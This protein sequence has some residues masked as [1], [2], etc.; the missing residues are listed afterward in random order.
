MRTF[1]KCT[2]VIVAAGVALATTPTID[3]LNIATD[4]A[5]AAIAT[6]DTNTQFGDNENEL[7][8]MFVTSDAGNMYIGLT[9]NLSD[10]NALLIFIDTN[11]TTGPGSTLNTDP[12]GACPGDVPTLLR[13]ASGTHFDDNFQPDYCLLVSVGKFPGHSDFQLVTACDLTNLNTL[14]NRNLGIGTASSRAGLPTPPGSGL[15][16]GNSGARIAIDN[17]NAAGVGNFDVQPTPNPGDAETA[18]SG[19]EIGIPKSLMGLTNGQSVRLVAWITNNAQGGGGGPC[20]RQG[21]SSNQTLAGVGGVANLGAFEP[22]FLP[23]D[24]ATQAAGNQ[25]V[26]V[27]VP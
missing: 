2:C 7:N 14:V 22:G 27:T 8:R 17:Q 18:L 19:I 13:I 1:L 20:N 23:I 4:F 15:L 26:Q 24:F 11:P 25:W 12:G 3:G 9:G 6:Q 21:F 5:S 16:T 10:N